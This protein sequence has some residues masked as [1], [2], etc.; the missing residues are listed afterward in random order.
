MNTCQHCQQNLLPLLYD[1]LD[2]GEAVLLRDHLDSCPACQEAFA[3]A[4]QHQ[5]TLAQAARESF[6]QVSFSPPPAE[7]APVARPSI[8]LTRPKARSAW[9]RWAVAASVVLAVGLGYFGY[10]G[11]KSRHETLEDAASRFAKADR[12]AGD[13]DRDVSAEQKRLQKEIREVSKQVDEL[14]NNRRK[15]GGERHVYSHNNNRVTIDAPGSLQAGAKNDIVIHVNREEKKGAAPPKSLR[16]QVVNPATKDVLFEKELEGSDSYFLTLPADLPLKPG[17]KFALVI[18]G[19]DAEGLPL[20]VVDHM[21]LVTAEYVTHLYLDRPLYRPGETVRFRSLTLERFS[22]Q[23]TREPMHLRFALLG[24]DGEPLQAMEKKSLVVDPKTGDPVLGPDGEPI[25]SIGL[26]EFILPADLAKGSYTLEVAELSQRFPTEK[27][28][29]QVD[30]YEAPLLIKHLKFG[31]A[32]YGPGDNV[33]V[34]GN[35]RRAAGG[36]KFERLKTH[37]EVVV[38]GSIVHQASALTDIE[39]N[40]HFNFFL[41]A[42][43]EQGDGAVTVTFEVDKLRE[44]VTT[45]PEVIKVRESLTRTLPIVVNKVLVDFYPEGGNLVASV[46]NRVYFQARTPL[47][48]PADI[49]GVL[50]DESDKVIVRAT[51]MSDAKEPSLNQGMGRFDFTPEAGRRYRFKVLTPK[52]L[53]EPGFDLPDVKENGLVVSVPKGVVTKEI[54][55]VVHSTHDRDL[56]VGAYCRGKLLDHVPLSVKRGEKAQVKLHAPPGLSGVYRITVFEKSKGPVPRYTPLA[57]RL[58]YS[59]GGERLEI[60]S[61]AAGRAFEP[62]GHAEL[63]LEV[64][65]ERRE[66]APS[67]LLVGVL[68]QTLVKLADDNTL[69]SMPTHFLLTSE[70]RR[71]E[72]LENVDVLL[73]KHPR[74]EEALDLLL[75]VQ[76]WRRFAEQDPGR[77]HERDHY[78][79]ARLAFGV[80]PEYR[81]MTTSG[82][83]EF[84]RLLA[85]DAEAFVQLQKKLATAETAQED[86]EGRRQVLPALKEEAST[87]GEQ[88]R[89]AEEEMLAFQ[90]TL[91]RGVMIFAVLGLLLLI[92]F[93]IYGAAVRGDSGNRGAVLAFA[94]GVLVVAGL[95]F[96]VSFMPA[97]QGG[98][99]VAAGNGAPGDHADP[100][101]DR[102]VAPVGEKDTPKETSKGTATS[103]PKKVGPPP[104]MA[105]KGDA[106]PPVRGGSGGPMAEGPS[107]KPKHPPGM[108]MDTAKGGGTFFGGGKTGY[109]GGHGGVGFT[110]KGGEVAPVMSAPVVPGTSPPT[111]RPPVAPL[112]PAPPGMP[113]SEPFPGGGMPPGGS[114]GGPPAPSS[115]HTG[116]F[117]AAPGGKVGMR[118]ALPKASAPR[119]LLPAPPAADAGGMAVFPQIP[120]PPDKALRKRGLYGDL[121]E[122]YFFA[123]AAPFEVLHPS[124]VRVYAYSLPAAA[125]GPIES[126]L[127]LWQPVLVCKEGKGQVAFDL[128]DLA[129][130]YQVIVF[131]HAS[132]GRLGAA[133]FE[134]NVRKNE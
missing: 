116:S 54:D 47:G 118:P 129:T 68:D 24:P 1:L 73:G 123:D 108:V 81:K 69:R 35:A 104:P 109:G 33:Q 71:P 59:R 41:P 20:R 79:A 91:R 98:D 106:S 90:S 25:Q 48:K 95:W 39:G 128:S 29:F 120:P 107:I 60:T 12:S 105:S 97:R 6:A 10:A 28:S 27:R 4:R 74:A 55:A 127:L 19:Q 62:R 46:P 112:M 125:K 83:L 37:L 21:S 14:L 134:I 113:L 121:T 117:G 72:D 82:D 84:D 13:L 76:G 102:V 65:D 8:P 130:T 78:A 64:R 3:Q 17:A 30:R 89:K 18:E 87:L 53:A 86:N 111:V 58:I 133:T 45:P 49:E 67:I 43:L 77:F 80:L 61:T 93:R 103:V 100:K 101:A 15:A 66:F 110:G 96:A 44:P 122:K 36:L 9:S 114:G 124:A 42:P 126:E 119:V 34:Q 50:L 88:A 85:R 99:P 51:T 7:K 132:D 23:P 75:G 56:L 22:L 70:V 11:W 2:E 92:G 40:Y 32:S 31:K 16:A 38:D 52:K 26:G 5:G 94:L 131:G 57:E 63:P 115:V